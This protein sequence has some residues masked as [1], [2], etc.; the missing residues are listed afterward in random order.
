MKT[1]VRL[2]PQLRI[3]QMDGLDLLR[4]SVDLMMLD[5][6]PFD[7]IDDAVSQLCRYDDAT[8]VNGRN[9]YRV[10]STDPYASGYVCV[11]AM[12]VLLSRTVFAV[13]GEGIQEA[14]KNHLLDFDSVSGDALFLAEVA[15]EFDISKIEE[16][17]SA[18]DDMMIGSIGIVEWFR[19]H[20][21]INKPAALHALIAGLSP[22]TSSGSGLFVLAGHAADL[23]SSHK[24]LE[25]H[26][27]A[28][29]W[30]SMRGEQDTNMHA[31][32]CVHKETGSILIACGLMSC[33]TSMESRDFD[34]EVPDDVLN[35]ITQAGSDADKPAERQTD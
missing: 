25:A 15:S 11:A 19:S 18:S 4:V 14:F 16:A 8:Q 29:E 21:C 5:H 17:A 6:E 9:R 2:V 34:F 12:D 32:P 24:I 33:G 30:R 10:G 28:D 27:T 26:T 1:N 3:A 13:D 7:I 23:S 31:V 35:G 22:L 20:T